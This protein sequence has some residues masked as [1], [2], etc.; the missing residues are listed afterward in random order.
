MPD[1]TYISP[2]GT[3]TTLEARLGDSVME[4]AVKHGV[5]GI[6]AE[7]GGACSCATCHVYVDE[8]F[9]DRV[10]GAGDLEDDMLDGAAA[11]RLPN[12][13]LSCQIKMRDELDGLLVRIAPEQL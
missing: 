9:T 8:A 7:C 13:R 6:V 5:E 11:E 4:V 2:D 12:S 1:I 3:S 10:G